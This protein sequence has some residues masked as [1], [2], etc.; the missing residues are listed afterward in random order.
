MVCQEY[1]YG[2]TD[3]LC[4][5]LSSPRTSSFCLLAQGRQRSRMGRTLR[6]KNSMICEKT[7]F[8]AYMSHIQASARSLPHGLEKVEVDHVENLIFQK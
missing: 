6:G 1:T 3:F 2:T 7:L 5:P 4:G 8:P